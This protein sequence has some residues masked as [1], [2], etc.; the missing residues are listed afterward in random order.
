MAS[1][2]NRSV[3]P[4][5]LTMGSTLKLNVY[6]DH[7]ILDIFINDTWASSVRVFAN[8]KSIENTTVFSTSGVEVNNVYGWNLKTG[9]SDSVGQI[10]EGNNGEIFSSD[11]NLCYSGISCP[12]LLTVYNTTGAAVMN[13]MLTDN[14][15]VVSSH[16]SGLHIAYK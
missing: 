1:D 13:T 4:Q 15:G 7:S 14:S 2:S 10:Y 3:L 8:E 16:L 9:S 6:F 12:A 5:T 11:S